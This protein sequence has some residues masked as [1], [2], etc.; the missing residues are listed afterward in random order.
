MRQL[1]IAASFY[2]VLLGSVAAFVVP[3]ALQAAREPSPPPSVSDL[4]RSA[5]NLERKI[6]TMGQTADRYARWRTCIEWVPVNEVGD[7]DNTFGYSYDERDGTGLTYMPALAV[8]RDDENPDYVFLKFDRRDECHSQPTVP[9]GTAEDAS[10]DTLQITLASWRETNLSALE[11]KVEQL[12][13]QAEDLER[14]SERFDEWESCLS[15]VP[16]TEYGDARRH[17]GYLFGEK[18]VEPSYGPAIAVDSSEWD[19]PDYEFLA[20]VGR[21]RPFSGHE[22]GH[23]PGEGVD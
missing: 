11:K 5:Q 22:C 10:V 6:E 17:F 21:D 15:W 8:D 7:P 2:A 14:M 19:D 20:F 18:G 9:G 23:E 3:D 12:K 16:V 4:E 13:E 1:L